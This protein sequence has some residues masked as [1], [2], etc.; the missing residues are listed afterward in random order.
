MLI[1]AYIG[2]EIANR[3]LTGVDT[4]WLSIPL[5]MNA[6]PVSFIEGVGSIVYIRSKDGRLF[7]MELEEYRH[8]PAWCEV[9]G[10][11]PEVEMDRRIAF[12]SCT[13]VEIGPHP[14]WGVEPPSTSIA[15]L[16]C[17]HSVNP[18]HN[19]EMVFVILEDGDVMRWI[20]DDP[21]L[22]ALGI[23]IIYMG[24]GAVLG[25]AIGLLLYG[26]VLW[27]RGRGAMERRR[28]LQ[29]EVARGVPQAGSSD[30]TPDWLD[31]LSDED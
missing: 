22:G 21:G 7:M 12:G 9:E 17:L 25:A 27:V 8:Q 2:I 3:K 15:Q 19:V 10:I 26:L 5:P 31:R 4:P 14:K 24:L 29:G 28:Y 1:G 16:N 11:L 18:D 20:R 23:F 30:A 6:E 13:P